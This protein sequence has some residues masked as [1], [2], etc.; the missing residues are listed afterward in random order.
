MRTL[1]KVV[2]SHKNNLCIIKKNSAD[3]TLNLAL[4]AYAC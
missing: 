3:D 2:T 4:R 1:S